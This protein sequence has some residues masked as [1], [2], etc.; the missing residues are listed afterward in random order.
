MWAN[1]IRIGGRES[2]RNDL[3]LIFVQLAYGIQAK[4]R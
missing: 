3:N 2:F 1:A 4:V